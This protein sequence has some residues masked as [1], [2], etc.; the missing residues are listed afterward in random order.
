MTLCIHFKLR[1][2]LSSSSG[3]TSFLSEALFVKNPCM[4][5]SC[6]TQNGNVAK[7]L[8]FEA[9]LGFIYCFIF[10]F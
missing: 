4:N 8:F 9:A 5:V 10:D 3:S 6:E 7:A 1:A 2:D